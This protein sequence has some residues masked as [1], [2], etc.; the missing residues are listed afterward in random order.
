MSDPS[1]ARADNPGSDHRNGDTE[2]S[3][4]AV[5]ANDDS[6]DSDSDN[7][8]DPLAPPGGPSDGDS[9]LNGLD[10]DPDDIIGAAFMTDDD[11]KLRH[12]AKFTK[13]ILRAR[14]N[15][16]RAR[17]H[18]NYALDVTDAYAAFLER[19]DE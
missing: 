11:D 2:T 18:I 9:L 13:S 17:Q 16:R 5:D 6:N 10:D 4:A 19:Q 12:A 15:I 14:R 1:L 8:N 7:G 3:S